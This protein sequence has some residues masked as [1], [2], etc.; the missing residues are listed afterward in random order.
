MVFSS[1]V[2]LFIFLPV[3][4]LLH[5]LIKNISVRNGLLIVA[6][7]IF[8]A[9][10]EPVYIALLILSVF[11]NYLFG[12]VLYSKKNK[13]I[14]GIAVA[15]NLSLLVVYKYTGFLVD[16]F[17]QI[18]NAKIPIPE[19]VMPIG[20]S[21]FT[22]QAISYIV[23]V[24][25]GKNTKKAGFFEVLLY[26]SLFP[27]LIAGPIVQY[28]SVADQI[29]ERKVTVD[30]FATGIR[31]FIVGLS[32]K[33]LIANT[34]GLAADKIFA[35][36]TS[37]IGMALAW[38]GAISYTLQIYFDFSGY[39]D[40]AVGI[41]H[42]LGFDFPE[43][44][45]YPYTATSIRDFW[46]RWH[47]SLTGWFREYLYIPLGG[48]RKGRARQILNS[49]I[50]FTCTGIWH[51]ANLTFLVWGFFHGVLISVETLL[52]RKDKKTPKFL[53]PFKWLFTMLAVVLGFVIFRADS[54]SYGM[55][56]ITQM[57]TFGENLSGY[58]MLIS[59]I[60]PSYITT[61]IVAMLACCP[62]VPVISSALKGNGQKKSKIY[63]VVDVL[64][65]VVSLALFMLCA[66]SLASNSYNPFIYFRF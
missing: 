55:R 14:L 39:S 2:F 33:M 30:K 4:L 60:T 16:T 52:Q 20:I 6:S 10:G 41:G 22:F 31:R 29:R 11:V 35:M 58:E 56:Y 48:N 37:D 43:N 25:R 54:L 38:V 66:M 18:F 28:N 65:Y 40:M 21:F 62:L 3:V 5:T 12:R 27:Q 49:M 61:A 50:V 17:N 19:I 26:I 9:F 44:F 45:K 15:L 53:I 34:M 51:G 64:G 36:E 59:I 47:M 13:V 24:Y 32:K 57:F 1:A 63:P 8:Y 7:L 46:R 42:I 23:D